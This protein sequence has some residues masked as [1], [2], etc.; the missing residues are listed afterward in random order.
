M[1]DFHAGVAARTIWGEARNQGAPGMSAVAHVI[2][3]RI[4]RVRWGH[5]PA[6]VCL[7]P[8]QFSCWNPKDPNRRLMLELPESDVTFAQCVDA[9]LKSETSADPTFGATHYQV[10]GTGANWAEGRTPCAIIGA[11]EFFRNIA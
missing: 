9:W 6:S 11:H 4:A 8:M 3:N 5:T 1:I 2:R 10:T 7:A